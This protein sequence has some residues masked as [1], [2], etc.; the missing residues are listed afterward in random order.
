M[1][2]TV[3]KYGLISGLVMALLMVGTFGYQ[4]RIPTSQALLIGYTT[5]VL[6][7][8][9]IYFGVRS[10][11]DTVGGGQLGFGRALAIGSLIAL[12]SS[13]CYVAT[14]EVIYFNF[15]PDFS[16]KYAAQQIDKV[17][18]SGA[19]QAQIDAK[20]VEMQKFQVSYANPLINAAYTLIE[21]LPVGLVIALVSAGVLRRGRRE[22]PTADLAR[23]GG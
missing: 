8:L 1:T 23:V 11:R 10:Y 17:R 20:V 22:E 21:P 2:K 15:M 16:A 4:E 13:C 9:L 18:K 6:S 5:I 3:W 14:W 19:T 7:F 12:I